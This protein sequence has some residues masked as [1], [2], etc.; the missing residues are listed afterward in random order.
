MK[1]KD[2]IDL[3]S[4]KLEERKKKVLLGEL[5]LSIINDKTEKTQ[6]ILSAYPELLNK[7]CVESKHQT[8]TPL[9]LALSYKRIKI[10]EFAFKHALETADLKH[11]GFILKSDLSKQLLNKKLMGD[12]LPLA[13]ACELKEDED[14]DKEKIIDALLK[15]GAGLEDGA[16]LSLCNEQFLKNFFYHA[17]QNSD[18]EKIKKIVGASKGI[19]N[20]LLPNGLLPLMIVAN[21]K[22]ISKEVQYEIIIFLL[23]SGAGIGEDGV[24]KVKIIEPCD[25]F[26]RVLHEKFS[27]AL[28]SGDKDTT[29]LLLDYFPELIERWFIG[30]HHKSSALMVAAY[31]NQKEIVQYLI[32]KKVNV[33]AENRKRETAEDILRNEKPDHKEIIKILK[34]AAFRQALEKQDYKRFS[35]NFKE[36]KPKRVNDR[37]EDGSTPLTKVL[38][39]KEINE[40]GGRILSDLLRNGADL[41]SSDGKGRFPLKMVMDHKVPKPIG[42]RVSINI[43]EFFERK[44]IYKI[45]EEKFAAKKQE[46]R[47]KLSHYTKKL[48]MIKQIGEMDSEFK[49]T[50][51]LLKVLDKFASKLEELNL[52]STHAMNRFFDLLLLDGELQLFLKE[53]CY[54]ILKLCAQNLIVDINDRILKYQLRLDERSELFKSHKTKD[55]LGAANTLRDNLKSLENTIYDKAKDTRKIKSL[56]DSADLSM[57]RCGFF[58]A[59]KSSTLIGKNFSKNDEEFIQKVDENLRAIKSEVEMLN[60]TRSSFVPNS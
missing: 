21:N 45:L 31:C 7:I 30:E 59:A 13:I 47:D 35:Q 11:V 6:V 14:G 58:T 27:F 12:R 48:W 26:N 29:I 4:E 50:S 18:I 15:N 24:S 5:R 25:F 55:K 42:D 57:A 37:F 19:V 28:R 17:L 8:S 22:K 52:T 46:I 51:S 40:D 20:K 60:E 3:L 16:D 54:L 49:E 32:N 41:F 44:D 38:D 56:L 2:K 23:K 10:V 43:E 36:Q 34:D 39:C 33:F 9:T 53:P 1:G